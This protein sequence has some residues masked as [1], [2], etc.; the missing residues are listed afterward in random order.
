MKKGLTIRKLLAVVTASV[1]LFTTGVASQPANAKYSSVDWE[2]AEANYIVALASQNIGIQQSAAS[3]IAEYQL[4]G[5]VEPLIKVLRSDKVEQVRMSA[6]L[7]L[8]SLDDTRARAAVEDA[9][10]YDGSDKVAKFCESLLNATPKRF[11]A[12]E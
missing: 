10:L 4:K 5:A 6:A 7:A 3:F 8:I 9:A 1:V 11:S 2:K 12:L